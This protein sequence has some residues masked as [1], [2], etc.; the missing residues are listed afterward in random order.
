MRV[1]LYNPNR[2]A[3][4]TARL[5]A[6]ARGALAAGESLQARCGRFG[7]EVVRDAASLAEAEAGARRELPGLADEGG[8][9]VVLLAIS[10][11]GAADAL[12]SALAR[13][14]LL[15]MTEAAVAVAAQCG[16]RVG[17]LT[18]GPALLPLYRARLEALLPAS[19]IAGLEAPELPQA[20]APAAAG[21]A[22]EVLPVLA[23]AARR[24]VDRGADAV[25]LAG[26]VLCGYERALAAAIDRPVLD[27]VA[28]AVHH[29]RALHRLHGGRGDRIPAA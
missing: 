19:R 18:L 21:I 10:L 7:P 2:S 29:L 4:I 25:V 20:F 3:H 13:R 28:C 5:E 12:R 23:E 8:A 9:D 6:S 16:R 15:G 24:L 17:L 11:D 22:P 1:L 14:P 27:G 26:A